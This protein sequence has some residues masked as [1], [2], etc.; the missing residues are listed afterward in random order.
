MSDLKG[1][2]TLPWEASLCGSIAGGVSAAITTPLNVA[3][4]RLMLVTAG[5]TDASLRTA[6]ML[7]LIAKENGLGGLFAGVAPRVTWISIG[8]AVFFGVYE[9]A[10][11]ILCQ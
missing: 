10:K 4:T 9:K 6:K 5:S 2:P 11:S 1:S 8:G 7:V 3:R